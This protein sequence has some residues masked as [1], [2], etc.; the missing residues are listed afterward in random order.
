MWGTW[1]AVIA[2]LFAMIIGVWKF[3]GRKSKEK[4]ERI[5]EADKLHKE[6]MAERDP[7]KITAANSRLNNDV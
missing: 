7:S 3:F 4:R 5:N 2:S 6:G 1:G